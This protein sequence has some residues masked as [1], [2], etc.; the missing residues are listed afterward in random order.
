M[1]APLHGLTF[2]I[3]SLVDLAAR[4]I[5]VHRIILATPESERSRMWGSSMAAVGEILDGGVTAE[6]V[7]DMVVEAVGTPL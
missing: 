7:V 3:P 5:Y 1:L 6:G 2:I 4:K